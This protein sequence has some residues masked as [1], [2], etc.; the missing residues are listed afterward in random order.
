MIKDTKLIQE[1][2]LGIATDKNQETS[3]YI[4]SIV[5]IVQESK[6]THLRPWNPA[7]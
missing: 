7:A 5:P 6:A 3:K 2:N 1:K 4:L